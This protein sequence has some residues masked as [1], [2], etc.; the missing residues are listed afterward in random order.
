VGIIQFL[1]AMLSKINIYRLSSTRL[2]ICLCRRF[3]ILTQFNCIQVPCLNRLYL[4]W[5]EMIAT[6]TA[7]EC[8]RDSSFLCQT[9]HEHRCWRRWRQTDRQTDGHQGPHSWNFL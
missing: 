5:F 6:P 1:A 8:N 4:T 3:T 2:Y 9:Q 7:R